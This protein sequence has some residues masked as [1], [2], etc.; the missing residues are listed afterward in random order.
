MLKYWIVVDEEY[1]M[2]HGRRWHNGDVGR[3]LERLYVW[4][5][6]IEQRQLLILM[7]D[8]KQERLVVWPVMRYLTDRLSEYLLFDYIFEYNTKNKFFDWILLY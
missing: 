2:C 5:K 4:V 8:H 7:S 3:L 1:S 6:A